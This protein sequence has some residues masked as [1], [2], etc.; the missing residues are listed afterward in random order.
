MYDLYKK[1]YEKMYKINI[2]II[3]RK[4]SNTINGVDQTYTNLLSDCKFVL[5]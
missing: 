2:I 1:W 3:M 5:I 4:K